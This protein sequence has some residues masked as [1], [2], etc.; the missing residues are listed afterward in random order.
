MHYEHHSRISKS[1]WHAM[2]LIDTHLDHEH[3]KPYS[4]PQRMREA[5]WGKNRMGTPYSNTKLLF[6]SIGAWELGSCFKSLHSSFVHVSWELGSRAPELSTQNQ[7]KHLLISYSM[8]ILL[9]V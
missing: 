6:S 1:K 8:Q 7:R 5:M 3:T 2:G 9:L 4:Q